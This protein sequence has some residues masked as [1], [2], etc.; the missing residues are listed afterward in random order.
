MD[1]KNINNLGKNGLLFLVS[2]LWAKITKKIDENIYSFTEAKTREN[3]APSDPI[4]IIFGKIMKWFSDLSAGAASTLLG[5]N[6]TAN[7]ALVSDENGKVAAS[8]VDASKVEFLSKVKSDI[9]SQLDSLNS[10]LEGIGVGNGYSGELAFTYTQNE[11][12]NA[13]NLPINSLA[14]TFTSASNIPSVTNGS[15]ILTIGN[16]SLRVQICF[17]RSDNFIYVRDNLN[18][19]WKAWKK[20]TTS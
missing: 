4:K 2:T 10:T 3:I 5:Q 20:I 11:Y 13:N 1:N 15:H 18:G 6:L 8:N 16:S 17:S 19:S 14:Y 12:A 9:Q 7:K